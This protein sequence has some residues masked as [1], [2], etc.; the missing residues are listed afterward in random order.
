VPFGLY[1][2][3]GYGGLG[4]GVEGMMEVRQGEKR[5]FITFTN[6]VYTEPVFSDAPPVIPPPA[7]PGPLD[8]ASSVLSDELEKA[9]GEGLIPDGFTG[10][11]A[12]STSRTQA[13]EAIVLLVEAIT[14]KSIADIAKEKG[15]NMN[16]GWADTDSVSATFLKAAGI[17]T[18]V[19]GVNYNPTGDFTRAQMMIMLG[20]MAEK[21]LGFDLSGYPPGSGVFSDIP[22]WEG[23][24]KYIGW[25][26]AVEITRGQGDGTFGSNASLQNQHTG[27]FS[28]RAFNNINPNTTQNTAR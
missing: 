21:V 7:P 25:A 8:G 22:G 20:R 9:L 4:F 6:Y 10:N 5:G 1:D 24:D 23:A 16:D 14:G 27:A 3:F 28:Y 2:S 26:A 15:F 19:D 11:W 18:G 13:A 12:R 17:S